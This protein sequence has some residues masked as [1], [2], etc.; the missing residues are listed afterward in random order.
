MKFM[1]DYDILNGAKSNDEAAWERFYNFYAPLIRLHGRDCGLKNENLEDLI[2][3]VMVTLSTQMPN[4]VY[5]PSKGRFRDY[6]RKII[7][8]RANDMLRKIY[9]QERIPYEEMDEVDLCDRF[10]EEWRE[11]ILTRSLEKLKEDVCLRHYQIFYLLDIQHYKVK[12]LAEL[13]RIPLVSIYTIRNRVEA[14]LKKI[15]KEMDI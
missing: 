14:K 9:R 1:T 5:D 8:A 15:V 3:N 13:Y 11:H 10:E 6:L 7:R 4:F 12:E 2:Q